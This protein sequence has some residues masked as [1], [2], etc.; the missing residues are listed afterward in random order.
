[1]RGDTTSPP[2]NY[3]CSS[4]SASE[5]AI[6]CS[7]NESLSRTQFCSSSAPIRALNLYANAHI[8]QTKK[9]HFCLNHQKLGTTFCSYFAFQKKFRLSDRCCYDESIPNEGGAVKIQQFFQD[10]NG[11]YSATRLAFL[12]WIIGTFVV[13]AY[14]AVTSNDHTFQVDKSVMTLLGILMTGKVVQSFSAGD[15][16]ASPPVQ[17]MSVVPAI[18]PPAQAVPAPIAPGAAPPVGVAVA[19]PAP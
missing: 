18:A 6:R 16:A 17:Q 12:L 10:G 14:V 8:M 9:P 7:C 4:E 19:I 13:S 2:T 5:K 1:M 15:Q 11:Q 3:A